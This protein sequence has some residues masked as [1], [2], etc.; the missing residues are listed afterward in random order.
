MLNS[1]IG[2]TED[3]LLLAVDFF[4]DFDAEDLGLGLL[5]ELVV[6]F[7]IEEGVVFAFEDLG[8]GVPL[9][10]LE[11]LLA[12]VAVC[13]AIVNFGCYGGWRWWH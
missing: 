11:A 2:E 10:G 9:I 7:L 12:G 5:V 4:E 1:L 8:L 13:F 3:L 6:F